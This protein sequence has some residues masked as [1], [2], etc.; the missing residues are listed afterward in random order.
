MFLG[1]PIPIRVSSQS[2]IFNKQFVLSLGTFPR[3]LVWR[4]S[5]VRRT[6]SRLHEWFKRWSFYDGHVGNKNALFI[7]S[8][9]NYSV[10]FLPVSQSGLL[11][12]RDS[13]GWMS[14]WRR[15]TFAD[16]SVNP[17]GCFPSNMWDAG[18]GHRSRLSEQMKGRPNEWC[19]SRMSWFSPV[20]DGAALTQSQCPQPSQ[21]LLTP[22]LPPRLV[23]LLGYQLECRYMTGQLH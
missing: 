19:Q 20:R 22:R 7:E 4:A 17:A 21:G 16:G 23:L 6:V 2:I 14:R 3:L 11:P 1:L 5:G 18:D 13:T 9:M 8:G 15:Q 10:N 12:P